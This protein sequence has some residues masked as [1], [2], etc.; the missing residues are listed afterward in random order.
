MK[1][2]L[3]S[4]DFGNS[5]S[6]RAICDNLGKP[7][8]ECH[9][10]YF[11]NERYTEEKIQKGVYAT[12][13]EK[14]GFSRDNIHVAEYRN[15]EPY[16]NLD[17]DTV[18]ISGGNTFA[19]MKLIR[20]AGFDKVIS[21]YVRKG[22]IYIGGSAGAHIACVDIS[23]VIRYDENSVGLTDFNGLGLYPGILICHYSAERRE[24]LNELLAQDKYTVRMLTDEDVLVFET[25]NDE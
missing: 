15:P 24:H 14:F 22:A 9:V 19:T 18:Y 6:A 1:L 17:I 13:L 21:E 5:V 20:N 10:L 25:S 3:S 16:L 2:I 4:C 12:R 8:E 7:I 23:H 11:P